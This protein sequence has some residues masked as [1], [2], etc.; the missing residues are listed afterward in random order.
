MSET[1]IDIAD[2]Y[3]EAAVNYEPQLALFWGRANALDHYFR[4][5]SQSALKQWHIQQDQFFERLKKIESLVSYDTP[6]YYT[7]RI[8]H[9]HLEA[10]TALRDAHQELWDLDPIFGWHNRA[11]VSA[12]KVKVDC[13][14]DKESVLDGYSFLAQ[15]VDEE[16]INLSAG[17]ENGF[18]APKRVVER[19]I[20]QINMM[21]SGKINTSPFF[22]LT[23]NA[24]D[25]KFSVKVEKLIEK[26]I[27]PSLIRFNQF[28][29]EV[30][31]PKASSSLGISTHPN[32]LKSYQNFIYKQTTLNHSAEKIYQ[33][34]QEHL[35]AIKKEIIDI[36]KRIFSTDNLLEILSKIRTSRELYFKSDEAQ[37]KYNYDALERAQSALPLWFNQPPNIPCTLQPYP[38]ARAKTGAPGEYHPPSQD[39]Q[40]GTYYINTYQASQRSRVDQ[41][42]TLF[43]ELI[44]GHHY[45]VSTCLENKTAHP[46]NQYFF[47][48]GFVEGW[49]LYSE[50][51]ADEMQLYTDDVSRLGMLS[52]EALRTARL[53]VDPGIHCFNWSDKDAVQFMKDHCAM[54]EFILEAEVDRYA[55]QPAQATSYMLGQKEIFRLRNYCKST[56]LEKFNIKEFHDQILNNGMTTLPLLTEH[57][58]RWVENF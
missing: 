16:I 24:N 28:L 2:K 52:N 6:Y 44:P 33:L 36:G 54:D 4:D 38:L 15:I 31:L 21:Y 5:H 25:A 39:G 34:G 41:E 7:Y 51:L 42:A 58:H 17:L 57:V 53:V 3:E 20:N 27:N 49:A 10:E 23:Q 26:T 56:L 40:P 46:V 22:K 13:E 14:K 29:E 18:I 19:I 37:L 50:R 55:M 47:N 8:L 32:G 45:Q 1:I 9:Q 43:H 35:K 30:Y 12:E 11:A 48:P